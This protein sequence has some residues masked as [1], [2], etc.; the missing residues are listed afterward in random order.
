MSPELEKWIHQT[1]ERLA[2]LEE[3][4]KAR[5]ARTNALVELLRRQNEE[6]DIRIQELKR[7]QDD[8]QKP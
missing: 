4:D 1:D 7:R 5:D 3:K 2:K 8:T 6:L